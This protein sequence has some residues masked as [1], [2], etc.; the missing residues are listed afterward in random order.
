M[1]ACLDRTALAI[2][3]HE[4][5]YSL[6]HVVS[7]YFPTDVC[8][9]E[10]QEALQNDPRFFVSELEEGIYI[11]RDRISPTD[12]II[13]R[14]VVRWK[15]RMSSYFKEFNGDVKLCMLSQIIKRPD[16]VPKN[17]KLIDI[18]NT[19]LQRRFL[20]I[21]TGSTNGNKKSNSSEDLVI[22]YKHTPTEVEFYHEQW[23]KNVIGYL[24]QQSTAI[25]L[26]TIGTHVQKPKNLGKNQKLIDVV[27]MDTHP[28]KRFEITVD[29]AHN[30]LTRLHISSAYCCEVW[31]QQ[32]YKLWR[33]S[34]FQLLSE[35]DY[36]K[37]PRPAALSAKYT[38]RN[39]I[40]TDPQQRFCKAKDYSKLQ[41]MQQQEVRNPPYMPNHRPSQHPMDTPTPLPKDGYSLTRRPQEQGYRTHPEIMPRAG[42]HYRIDS[43]QHRQHFENGYGKFN[44]E[45]PLQHGNFNN[46]TVRSPPPGFTH[47]SHVSPSSG[48]EELSSPSSIPTYPAHESYGTTQRKMSTNN[49]DYFASSNSVLK[50]DPLANSALSL[51]VPSCLVLE[52]ST[53][54]SSECML[55]PGLFRFL[56]DTV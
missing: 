11:R 17:V 1:E 55:V 7:S 23:R 21:S 13:L 56:S 37:A 27:K 3:L 41:R 46:V 49:G 52:K 42:V 24:L 22:K 8:E 54:D 15:D 19:D 50:T 14:G 20:V 28:T 35:L 51:S 25:P 10:V 43:R 30:S 5:D 12:D 47:V 34:H 39:T 36:R 9:T 40:L 18:L 53:S 32:I 16:D 38:L 6:G 2:L 4:K 44:H 29:P 31:R 33:A 26:V 48:S 45:L